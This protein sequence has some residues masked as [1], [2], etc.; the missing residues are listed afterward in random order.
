M[1]YGD[2]RWRSV[3]GINAGVDELRGRFLLLMQV[4]EYLIFAYH[5]LGVQTVS[6]RAQPQ[7]PRCIG[8][9]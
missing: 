9:A 1:G 2:K 6:L 8:L 3:G 4:F 7:L 5:S